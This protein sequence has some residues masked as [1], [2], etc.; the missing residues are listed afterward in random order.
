MNKT[1]MEEAARAAGFH[2]PDVLDPASPVSGPP[3]ANATATLERQSLSR[4]CWV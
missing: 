2:T 3:S 4:R 1:A